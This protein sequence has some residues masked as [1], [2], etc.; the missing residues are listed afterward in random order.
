[1]ETYNDK[2]LRVASQILAGIV[3]NA[4]TDTMYMDKQ[5]DIAVD[6]A[7]RLIAKTEILEY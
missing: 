4:S 7:K 6:Y 5:V 2:I 3:V 1:M